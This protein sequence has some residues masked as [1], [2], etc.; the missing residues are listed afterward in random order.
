MNQTQATRPPAA[1]AHAAALLAG[2]PSLHGNP[3]VLR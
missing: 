3:D 2:C 1:V